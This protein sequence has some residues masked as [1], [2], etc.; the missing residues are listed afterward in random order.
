[1]TADD[2]TPS[3][4]AAVRLALTVADLRAERDELAAAVDRIRRRHPRGDEEPGPLAPWC[5]TCGQERSE[6]GYGA[7]P[8]RAAL[9]GG[10]Q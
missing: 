1:M 4:E 7:C 5:P 6:N 9:R 10:D 8:D 3:G 2:L